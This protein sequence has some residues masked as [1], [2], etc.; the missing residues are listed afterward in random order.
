MLS[1]I[2]CS[3]NETFVLSTS[4]AAYRKPP[5]CPFA[6][7]LCCALL[8]DTHLGRATTGIESSVMHENH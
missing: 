3:L 7:Q 5:E 6:S 4:E 8:L 2:W 1:E